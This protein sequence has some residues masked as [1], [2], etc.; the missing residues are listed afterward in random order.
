MKLRTL[1]LG[2]GL[3]VSVWLAVFGDKSP[4]DNTAQPAA[5]VT[6]VAQPVQVA[7]A[8]AGTTVVNGMPVQ[9][10][11]GARQVAVPVV[12]LELRAREDGRDEPVPSQLFAAQSWNPPAAPAGKAAATQPAPPPAAPPLPFTY[13]G[14]KG[15]DGVWEV[16]L[17][18]R[19]QSVVA[20]VN[21][22]VAGAYRVESITATS[23]AVTYLPMNEL[24]RLS[25]GP[26]D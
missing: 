21:T 7:Q 16:Y 24:Q 3:L 9:R 23:M 14:K 8:S 18:W 11:P 22:V 19:D 13:L 1:L 12:V 10:P 2:L 26:N 20:R 25:L 5:R 6:P 15:E 4:A 17:A